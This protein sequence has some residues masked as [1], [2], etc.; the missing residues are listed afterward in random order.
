MCVLLFFYLFR[1]VYL[2][3][4][5]SDTKSVKFMSGRVTANAITAIES[6][7]CMHAQAAK[8]ISNEHSKSMQKSDIWF[9]LSKDSQIFEIQDDK[10]KK[11][12]HKEI[13]TVV[14]PSLH[15]KGEFR[16]RFAV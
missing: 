9:E 13:L 7:Y 14:Y 4:A 2:C 16:F 6:H 3:A 15:L 1:W 8:C 11:G 5:C 12:G 10:D